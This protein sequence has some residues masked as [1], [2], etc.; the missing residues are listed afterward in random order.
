ML[1]HEQLVDRIYEAAA[2]PERWPEVLDGVARAAA[3]AGAALLVRRSDAWTGGKVSE[4]IEKAFRAYLSTDIA[5]RSRTTARLIAEDRAGFVSVA[6]VFTPAEWEADP[7]RA[8]WALAW[9]LDQAAAAAVEAPSGDVLVFH[10]QRRLGEPSFD[11]RD[12]DLLDAFRPHLARAGLL[13]ARWQME[14]LRA[15]AEALALVG[16]PALVLDRSGRALAAN[17]LIEALTD[18]LRWL[19]GDRIALVDAAADEILRRGLAELGAAA[20]APGR[21][22]AARSRSGGTTA[23]VH[24]IPTPGQAREIFNGALGV[25]LV[26]PVAAPEAP[27]AALLRGLFDLT[28]GEARVARGVAQGLT[29]DQIAVGSGVERETIRSQVK[30]VFEK[31]GARRQGDVASLLA[32]LPRYPA[33]G[34]RRAP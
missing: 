15:A 1:D 24:L 30:A 31:T 17:A 8:E 10:V 27:A 16:L 18:H 23:V 28:A 7:L 3:A 13:A 4:P 2:L 5:Q 32:G 34:A 9:G 19:P 21:S 33:G 29:I 6:E 11:R 26:T 12:L 22:F 20:A 25:L 14:R